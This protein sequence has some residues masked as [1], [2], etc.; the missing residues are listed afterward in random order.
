MQV[1]LA[2]MQSIQ[3]TLLSF[4]LIDKIQQA[5]DQSDLSRG[6]FLDF[7]KAFDIVDRDNYSDSKT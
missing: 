5:I 7:S 3:L 2:S 6:I 1:S 4:V